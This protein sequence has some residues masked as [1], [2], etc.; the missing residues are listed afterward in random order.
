MPIDNFFPFWDQIT[1]AQRQTL[2]A[3][4]VYHMVGKGTVLHRGDADCVGLLLVERGQLRAFTL[5]QEGR[6][7]TLYRLFDRDICLFSASCMLNSI[8]FEVMVEAEQDTAFWQVSPGVYQSIMKKSAPVANYTNELMASRFTD[9]MW[10]MDQVLYKRMD[11]RLA[12]FLLE[13]ARLMGCDE[14][15]MTHET[16]ANHLGS[17]REVVSRMLKYL[18]NEGMVALSRGGIRLTD[19]GKLEQL[20]ESSQR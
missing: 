17:A 13:E 6:E 2:T 11:A 20:A 14:L 7:I 8:Q 9:V 10:L 4:A 19:K 3:G 15:R 12:G 5:S 18:Q 1:P 16:I